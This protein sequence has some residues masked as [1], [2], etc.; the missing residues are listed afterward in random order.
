VA[1]VAYPII[2]DSGIHPADVITRSSDPELLQVA[3][4]TIWTDGTAVKWNPVNGFVLS[5]IPAARIVERNNASEL[6]DGFET[7]VNTS[8]YTNWYV[9]C[10]FTSMIDP[11]ESYIAAFLFLLDCVCG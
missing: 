2:Y 8:V 3:R 10:A 1:A 11:A 5:W 6:L 4:N 7:A 9:P